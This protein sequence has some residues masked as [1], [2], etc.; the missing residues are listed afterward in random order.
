METTRTD[1]DAPVK[2]S[3][4]GKGGFGVLLGLT[5]EYLTKQSC[6][7]ERRVYEYIQYC[8]SQRPPPT[9]VKQALKLR[10]FL[11][12]HSLQRQAKIRFMIFVAREKRIQRKCA[13]NKKGP[14]FL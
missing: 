10:L 7:Q 2:G 1:S 9:A 11:F 8:L 5:R 13:A 3:V 4:V 14:T 6:Q 12:R